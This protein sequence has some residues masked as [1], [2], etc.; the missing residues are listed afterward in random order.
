[1]VR[2][3]TIHHF[4]LGS[5]Y[6]VAQVRALVSWT[7]LKK[8]ISN[9]GFMSL[10][11][12]SRSVIHPTRLRDGARACGVGARGS[13]NMQLMCTGPG[14]FAMLVCTAWSMLVN[15]NRAGTFSLG[16]GRSTYLAQDTRIQTIIRDQLQGTFRCWGLQEESWWL[17]AKLPE[18]QGITETTL[19]SSYAFLCYA[20]E[21]S[22]SFDLVS[23]LLVPK[24][25]SDS[26]SLSI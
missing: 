26:A 2:P 18:N 1:M 23:F 14:G 7:R 12:A 10:F 5:A 4:D 13:R 17:L 15:R 21:G 3:G 8:A 25:R 20:I 22:V 11:A 24:T 6:Q 16:G 9:P 19:F